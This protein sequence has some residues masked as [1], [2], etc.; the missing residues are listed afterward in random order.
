M[1]AA[2]RQLAAP[3]QETILPLAE[4]LGA[5]PVVE[6]RADDPW[7]EAGRKVLAGHLG[8][9]LARAPGVVSGE[10]PEEVH[11]MR[12]ATR[13]MRAAMR[14]FGGA[15]D[16]RRHPSPSRRSAPARRPTR[17]R[18]RPRCL[19]GAPRRR[20]PPPLQTRSRRP[21]RADRGLGGRSDRAPCRS[22]GGHHLVVVRR[23]RHGTR[24]LRRDTRGRRPGR[25]AADPEPGPR[26]GPVR[27][28]GGL[29]DG[30]GVRRRPRA[31]RHRLPAPAADR[32]QVA[33][34]H[35]RVRA[36][37]ARH[38]GDRPDP[39]RRDPAGPARRDPRSP[40]RRVDRRWPTP[41]RPPRPT[42][43]PSPSAAS[44]R[45]RPRAWSGCGVG[46]VRPPVGSWTA[47]TG[48]ASGCAVARL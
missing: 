34:L 25:R 4:R 7:S 19:A 22:G 45:T 14:V 37:A 16:R 46:S 2:I 43:R 26:P 20:C 41:R 44:S 12:V 39:P 10:D 32:G 17:R 36:R 47:T 15:Y 27:A 9:V 23:C 24:R 33:A 18:P 31:G 11:A 21:A 3:W 28:V 48:A 8:R 6:V 30:L 40:R 13:R 5:A 1:S 42:P 35:P 29:P 38:A